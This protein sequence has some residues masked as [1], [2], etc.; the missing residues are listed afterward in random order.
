[1]THVVITERKQGC[2]VVGVE[3]AVLHWSGKSAGITTYKRELVHI[4]L[5]S[6]VV[7]STTSLSMLL[8]RGQRRHAFQKNSML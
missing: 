4:Y 8:L 3:E 5:C 1:M 2:R 6:Y 7:C